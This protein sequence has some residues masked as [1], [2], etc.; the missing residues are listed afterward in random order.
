MG[1]APGNSWA[2]RSLVVTDSATENRP[3]RATVVRVKWWSK[4]PPRIPVTDAAWQTP[5]EQGQIGGEENAHSDKDA[6]GRLHEGGGDSAP[7]GM[8]TTEATPYRTRLTGYSL[9]R[10][11]SRERCLGVVFQGN[12]RGLRRELVR[13]QLR[14]LLREK[15]GW[16]AEN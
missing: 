8:T 10:P 4:S 1:K 3:P 14:E 13:E 9:R 16:E 7:R 5:P 2:R 12:F 6:A 15:G 11:G